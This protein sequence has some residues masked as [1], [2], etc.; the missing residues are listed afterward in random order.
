[1]T[2]TQDTNL[3]S[4]ESRTSQEG[5]VEN[6]DPAGGSSRP[7]RPGRA[8]TPPFP[9]ASRSSSFLPFLVRKLAWDFGVFPDPEFLHCCLLLAHMS[10]VL[11]IFQ[12]L[13]E[14]LGCTNPITRK[15]S[16]FLEAL[17][18]LSASVS[19]INVNTSAPQFQSWYQKR[20]VITP[21]SDQFNANSWVRQRL[22]S[23]NLLLLEL[24]RGSVIL[25]D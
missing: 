20:D 4:P 8:P 3:T 6:S 16:W 23:L 1:M 7:F 25:M 2:A 22:L 9:M 18:N 19:F 14:S 17:F 5:V 10:Q 21:L 12:S 11:F 15:L 13:L 24:S